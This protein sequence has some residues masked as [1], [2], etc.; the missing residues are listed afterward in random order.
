MI[1]LL[2]KSTLPSRFLRL[3]GTKLS[4]FIIFIIHVDRSGSPGFGV[5]NP[6]GFGV[7]DPRRFR[8]VDPKGFGV[9]YPKGL[10]SGS[11]GFWSS[12]SQGVLSSGSQGSW[13]TASWSWNNRFFTEM[14]LKGHFLI[15][16]WKSKPCSEPSKKFLRMF[17]LKKNTYA[18]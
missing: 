13:S 14:R 16:L 6:Q 10:S 2:K 5:A 3:R 8:V 15:P 11:P 4:V 7:V 17:V 18:S 12:G 1:G 9:A